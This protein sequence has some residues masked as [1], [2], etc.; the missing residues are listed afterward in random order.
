M[1]RDPCKR[2]WEVEALED[3]RLSEKDRRSFERHVAGCL[4][5]STEARRLRA[6]TEAL[7]EL[8]TP[9]RTELARRRERA[10]LVARANEGVIHAGDGSRRRRMPLIMLALLAAVGVLV[11][12]VRRHAPT[13]SVREAAQSPAPLFEVAD[14]GSADFTSERVE[15]T[16][17]VVLRSGSAAFHV[18]RV[19]PGARF[20]VALPDGEVEVRGTRFV[21][22]V[23]EGH[24]RSVLVTEGVVAVR[25]TGFDGV[26]RAGERWPRTDAVV[27]NIAGSATPA[28]SSPASSVEAPPVRPPPSPSS[29][30]AASHSRASPPQ[31][32][33]SAGTR[34][35]AAMSAYT[36]GDYGEA[37]RLLVAFV[38]DFP[39]DTR[40]E[41]AMFLIAE[42]RMRRGDVP[43]AK[44]AARAYLRRF[45]DGLRAPA[46]T[47]IAR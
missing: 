14:V 44:E 21:V 34:F 10:A 27:R 17:R 19:R 11:L 45:P 47:Q 1:T 6:L 3:G 23:A 2:T 40:V 18:E 4:E 35:A 31:A 15:A 32:L 7:A 26:L 9:D 25:V 30:Q 28:S 43:G 39:S 29:E 8:P 20:L 22:D 12:V 33:A 38:R 46:A 36:A 5:C 13:E 24:T 41:D 16:S 37:D 42:A